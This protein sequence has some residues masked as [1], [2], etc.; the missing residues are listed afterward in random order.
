MALIWLFIQKL[1][2]QIFLYLDKAHLLLMKKLDFP[3]LYPRKQK[4]VH[5]SKVCLCK[6]I[7][8]CSALQLKPNFW[9][10][11][12]KVINLSTAH[13][14]TRSSILKRK[15]KVMKKHVSHALT[16]W[17]QNAYMVQ[18]ATMIEDNANLPTPE[19]VD[20]SKIIPAEKE[21]DAISF[22]WCRAAVIFPK[23][24]R[25]E[26]LLIKEVTGETAH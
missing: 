12:R 16:T 19:S 10:W 25:I 1:T 13:N 7:C 22:T 8:S 15:W 26:G 3:L 5:N 6:K 2:W 18:K 9:K 20:T 21:K 11:H 4:K 14:A 17:N 23:E 24:I